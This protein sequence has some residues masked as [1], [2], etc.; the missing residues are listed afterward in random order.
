M[1]AQVPSRRID[2]DALER[3]IQRAAELQAGEMD[4]GEGLTEAELLRLGSEVGIPARYLRQ[5]LYEETAAGGAASARSPLVRWVGPKTVLASRVVPGEKATLEQSL[6]DWMTEGEALAVKRRLPDRTVWERQRG[7]V[8][9]MK[10]G[11][12]YG[13]RSYE[14]AKARDVAAA[15]TQLEDGYCRVEMTADLSN[16][17][18]GY[19]GG[20][21]AVAG[22]GAL[23]GLGVLAISAVGTYG[24]LAFTASAG[25]G[26][27]IGWAIARTYRRDAERVQ[28][29][30]EQILDRLERG[31]IRP[32]HRLAGPRASAFTR[33]ADELRR[34]ITESPS[35]PQTPKGP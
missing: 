24:L 12:G 34:A 28:L 22:V 35:P 11:F 10:R 25:L 18:A 3:I 17:R 9:E 30:L 31:E 29:A 33:I 8:A 6:A 32:K 7:F 5:A 15:V 19:A 26:S 14:L 27:A 23:A 20:A 21:S 1:A 4:T 16:L 2:R 13:G